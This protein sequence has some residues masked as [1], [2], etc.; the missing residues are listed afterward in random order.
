M[1]RGLPKALL[2]SLESIFC[3][4]G[5]QFNESQL[6]L[7]TFD[8]QAQGE[9]GIPQSIGIKNC[10]RSL[11]MILRVGQRPSDLVPVSA[12]LFETEGRVNL[13][14]DAAHDMV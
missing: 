12:S 10:S 7:K 3:P 11:A 9:G 2:G 6:R 8:G 14:I 5:P 4:G 13:L 1:F